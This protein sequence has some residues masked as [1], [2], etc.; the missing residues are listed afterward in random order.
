MGASKD[1]IVEDYMQSYINYYGVKKGTDQYKMISEDVLA[2]LKVIA[3]TDD[4]DKADLA[5]SSEKY[6]L[7]GGMTAKQI[8]TL[9]GNLSFKSAASKASKTNEAVKVNN[10]SKKTPKRLFILFIRAIAYGA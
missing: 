3:G 8:E 5:A 2:M 9:K 6:L 7:S 1:E 10:S 4:L